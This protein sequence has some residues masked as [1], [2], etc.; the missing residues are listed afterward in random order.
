MGKCDNVFSHS[1]ERRSFRRHPAGSSFL[2]LEKG[3]PKARDLNATQL[4]TLYHTVHSHVCSHASIFKIPRLRHPLFLELVSQFSSKANEYL[5]E[6]S[7]GARSA[8]C[9]LRHMSDKQRRR[10]PRK[11]Q[12]DSTK[13]VRPAPRGINGTQSSQLPGTMVA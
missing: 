7:R 9:L 10:R 6:P 3:V 11:I 13:F 8:V 4:Q 1:H 12:L 2:P 5:R